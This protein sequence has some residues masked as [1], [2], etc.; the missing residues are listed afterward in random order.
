MTLS[1]DMFAQ[2]EEYITLLAEDANAEMTWRL[3]HDSDKGQLASVFKATLDEAEGRISAAQERG[4]GVF[5]NV[6]ETDGGGGK[7][8]VTR[9]RAVYA[10]FDKGEYTEPPIKPTFVVQSKNGKHLYWVLTDVITA[11][12][13]ED[14]LRR[15]TAK[16]GSDPKIKDVSRVLRVPGTLHQKD[17]NDTYEVSL[18]ADDV[19]SKYSY[20]Q[21]TGAFPAVSYNMPVSEPGP[22]LLVDCRDTNYGLAA[23]AKEQDRFARVP[24]GVGETNSALAAFAYRLGRLGGSGHIRKETAWGYVEKACNDKGYWEGENVRGVFESSWR[25]GADNPRTDVE[26]ATPEPV[27]T[28]GW[29]GQEINPDDFLIKNKTGQVIE[30]MR[31]RRSLNY[32][33]A[34]SPLLGLN[35][36]LGGG[37]Q[38]GGTTLVGA[39]PGYGKSSLCLE[40][41]RHGAS[42]YGPSIY[43]TL[44]MTYLECL[45][46]FGTQKSGKWSDY[47]NG[48]HVEVMEG[49]RHQMNNKQFYML[50]YEDVNSIDDLRRFA[51]AVAEKHKA[52]P[53]VVVDYIQSLCPPT[54][55]DNQMQQMSQVSIGVRNLGRDLHSPIVCVTSVN[56][57][58]YNMFD[59]RTKRPNRGMVLASAKMTGQLEYDAKAICGVCLYDLEN[60]NG[61]R[62]GWICVAKNR[63]GGSTGDI[64]VQF[65]G[66]QG[67]FEEVTEE[68]VYRWLDEQRE[69]NH[70]LEVR[71]RLI[72]AI[73][74]AGSFPNTED[75]CAS[76]KVQ[77]SKGCKEI[78]SLKQGG[79]VTHD[80]VRGYVLGDEG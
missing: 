37:A 16:L 22:C 34:P 69:E 27:V 31:R 18:I 39:P 74:A 70:G 8:N 32:R 25:A 72:E 5:V 11:G 2:I 80:P 76:A 14:L 65:N 75:W 50:T 40:W 66:K 35:N 30:E 73:E 54:V 6:N 21:L 77:K 46:R 62:F 45:T 19:A 55:E 10:E 17:P 42:T 48:H 23:A 36:M 59:Q 52:P 53:L 33:P 78:K 60:S 15:I 26:L 29:V 67:Q 13:A 3:I 68:D 38:M 28:D 12:Q 9:V 41:A 71:T 63:L 44:E 57:G 24:R 43:I 51:G 49:M 1:I 58:S 47:Y 61:Q 4:Y 79:F 56:R 7:V 64:P 20:D